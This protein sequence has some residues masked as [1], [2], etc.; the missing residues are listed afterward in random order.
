MSIQQRLGTEIHPGNLA[1]LVA[2]VILV[3]LPGSRSTCLPAIAEEGTVPSRLW[4]VDGELWSSRSRLPDFSFAGYRRGE[5]PYR[6]P[7][8]SISVKDFGAA[9]DGVTDDTESFRRALEAGKGKLIL[10]P[11]GRYALH[12]LFRIE[13]SG[14]V[15]RGAG[16]D[17]TVLEFRKPGVEI[18]PRPS[19][20]D[21]G[22]STSNWSWAGG[23]ISIGRGALSPGRGVRVISEEV[24]GSYRLTPASVAFKP[25]DEIILTLQDDEQKSLVKY[26]YR[27]QAGD[28]SG[29]NNWRVVQVFR[30]RKVEDNALVLDRP[31]RFDVRAQWQPTV[32]P[33]VPAVTDVG[34]EDLAFE[35]PVTRYQGHFLEVGFNP[36][37]IARSAAH[38]W[39]KNLTIRNADSGPY[40]FG[41]FCTVEGIR[42]QA[43]AERLS[44][45]GYAGHHGISLQGNDLLC[46]DFDI[47]TRFIHD[48]TVQSS[49]GCV[50]SQ[51]RAVDLCMDHHRW[52]SYEN[53]FTDI[54]AGSGRR[55]FA[56]SGG[57]N[58][59]NHSG[60][61]AT[62]WNIRSER[63]APW[64]N[65]QMD[66][67][68]IIGVRIVD[69]AKVVPQL[70]EPSDLKARWLEAVEPE[71]LRPANLYEA[72]KTRR[73]TQGSAS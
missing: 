27:D 12:D 42:L 39:L 41:F 7:R 25:G 47:E 16:P 18:E 72:M 50:F 6:I 68:N 14:T 67:I 17:K 65:W 55:L 35:F 62:F 54:D 31:L 48:L 36:I 8:E 51:G 43:D 40:V 45:Q 59:G 63:A 60:A 53:L 49:V 69:P 70:P 20:T 3:N 57:G 9:G 32:A 71:R 34:I 73:L 15:L 38:C 4:G 2:A 28:I 22:Q 33:F 37:E 46:K 11:A 66:A 21:G 29:L 19:R 23:L 24:R 56:S 58:R 30:V 61:G 44:S 10:I 52:A 1:I 5:E 13:A 64:P 26:L